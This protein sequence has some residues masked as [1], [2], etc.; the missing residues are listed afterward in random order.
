MEEFFSATHAERPWV[1]YQVDFGRGQNLPCR[2]IS[3]STGADPYVTE[4]QVRHFNNNDP[5]QFQIRCL[6][7]MI[8]RCCSSY[9]DT[10]AICVLRSRIRRTQ[11]NR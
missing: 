6:S 4:L 11:P 1:L 10:R 2:R 9:M 5:R 3:P 7:D 8:N